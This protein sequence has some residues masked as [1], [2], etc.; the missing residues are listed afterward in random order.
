MHYK[1]D[2]ILA[3]AK[4]PSPVRGAHCATQAAVES[5]ASCL[6]EELRP[7]NVDVVIVAA[8]ELAAGTAWLSDET[9]IDQVSLLYYSVVRINTN[10]YFLGKIDV[11]TTE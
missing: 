11:E 6:K 1:F 7:R 3:L 2:S 10:K 8:G 5:L 4:I 9:M